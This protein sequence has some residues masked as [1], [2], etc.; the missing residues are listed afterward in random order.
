MKR[1][2][3]QPPLLGV[4]ERLEIDRSAEI[5]DIIHTLAAVGITASKAQAAALYEEGMRG[6]GCFVRSND[7]YL[8]DVA[9]RTEL[10]LMSHV[11]EHQRKEQ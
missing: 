6:V 9:A 4:V 5:T 2:P 8:V 7:F 3:I 10:R 11:R 1:Q